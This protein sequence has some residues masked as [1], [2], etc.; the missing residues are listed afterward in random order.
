MRC[1]LPR[2]YSEQTCTIARALE[3][4][5]E[6]WTLLI[7][8]DAFL[9]VRRFD[10]FQAR[11]EISR[12]VLTRRLSDLVEIG[13]LRREP[14]QQRPV[15]HDYLLTERALELWPALVGLAQ[16]G[17]APEGRPR[18]FVHVA[19]GTAV[20]AVARCPH[21]EV[22]VPPAETASRPGPGYRSSA[23]LPD[24]LRAALEQPRPLLADVRQ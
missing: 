9:G 1:M 4:V 21:C 12:T 6:R 24:E 17:A 16:W 18:E 20:H 14:Y 15:R 10:D 8:R 23:G 19:C 5:G 13:L 11:L 2:T 22:D 7:L 3:V